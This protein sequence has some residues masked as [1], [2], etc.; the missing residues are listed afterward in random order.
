M[1]RI[2]FF[3]LTVFTV[4]GEDFDFQ[5]W[6]NKY[7]NVSLGQWT[8]ANPPPWRNYLSADNEDCAKKWIITLG[9]LGLRT[10]MHD[11]TWEGRSG[12]KKI[13]PK[14]MC[15]KSSLLYN[16]L[17]ITEVQKGSPAE[18][19]IQKGDLILKIEDQRLVTASALKLNK[20]LAALTV[21][22]LEMHAGMLIDR[23]EGKGKIKM[24]VLRLPENM[25]SKSFST[26]TREW[27]TLKELKLTPDPQKISMELE[28]NQTVRIDYGI[29][30][31]R[32]LEKADYINDN[33]VLSNGTESIRIKKAHGPINL[34]SGKWTLSG[35][36][37]S[38]KRTHVKIE[39]RPLPEFPT[40]LK[41]YLKAV[42]FEIPKVGS[43]GNVYKPNSSKVRTLSKMM[44][45]ALS[46]HQGPDGGWV[47]TKSYAS[48]SFY[49]SICGLAL[50]ATE[51]PIYNQ[52]IKKA[53]Q[54]VAA[55][56]GSQENWTFSRGTQ[57]IFLCEYYL[58]T[59]DAS[60][61]SRAKHLADLCLTHMLTDYTASHKREAAY[62][63]GGFIGSG[64]A[65]VCGLALAN[66]CGLLDQ[67]GKFTVSKALERAQQLAPGGKI[68]YGRYG[69]RNHDI[70][71]DHGGG[72]STGPYFSAALIHG[73][74]KGFIDVTKKR[75]TTGPYG[76]S[77]NGHATQIIHF[78]WSSLAI[79]N[80]G[81]QH[82][83][84]NMSAYIWKLTTERGF[85]G[86]A[87][88]NNAAV[89][90][91]GGDGVIG[92]PFWG[93]ASYLILLNAHKR[94]LAISGK[95]ELLSSQQ[96]ST[97]MVFHGD[98][99]LKN[100]VMRNWAVVNYLIGSK[101]PQVFLETKA[102]ISQ[103]PDDET[104]GPKLIKYLDAQMPAVLQSIH[105]LDWQHPE[106]AKDDLMRM[107]MGL[108]L[109][110][111][112]TMNPL[113][114]GA[115]KK[116]PKEEKNR[117]TKEYNKLVREIENGTLNQ[118]V[119]SQLKFLPVS[120]VGMFGRLCGLE[121]AKYKNLQ[122]KGSITIHK[123]EAAG[124]KSDW[125]KKFNTE[126]PIPSSKYHSIKAKEKQTQKIDLKANPKKPANLNAT[127]QY[128]LCGI[129]ISRKTTLKVFPAKELKSFSPNLSNLWI[130]G[131]LTHDFDG[132]RT[133][134]MRLDNGDIIAAEFGGYLGHR[135]V[136][137][138][139]L[140]GTECE[141]LVSP[142]RQW[143][144]AVNDIKVRKNKRTLEAGVTFDSKHFK[145]KPS[146]LSDQNETSSLIINNSKNER[147]LNFDFPSETLVDTL[148]ISASG[149]KKNDF[150][151][152]V[153]A[154]INNSWTEV[155]GSSLTRGICSFKAV[156][157]KKFRIKIFGASSK[158]T[159]LNELYLNRPLTETEKSQFQLK[160][161][162]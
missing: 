85:Q 70:R 89:E 102:K 99:A 9:P 145:G 95:T 49:T 154:L 142:D 143:S 41:K 87:V 69:A 121:S 91:H 78:L 15:D 76:T 97:P 56:A 86:H 124:I 136:N 25:K 59:K 126:Y 116:M 57:L 16:N 82:H 137:G 127:I 117:I 122:V 31:I 7:G 134:R 112:C 155:F 123:S 12:F 61:L 33:V 114:K 28:G 79:H 74:P 27:K 62:G 60:I 44:A 90:Y 4:Y 43:F 109:E 34:S 162:W 71:N 50:L 140:A 5:K 54:Y 92:A 152:K 156:S 149:T 159:K 42:E 19:Y 146:V 108:K 75:Y 130:K 32:S 88:F 6:Q 128:N 110:L 26:K 129:P 150:V 158:S 133:L 40:S 21:R 64:S 37:S 100:H 139:L 13:Y 14:A 30:K 23:A 10:L 17:E 113:N 83:I 48:R 36:L 151:F 148:V 120:L 118:A 55:V 67:Q 53:A 132:Q 105:K 107:L 144:L 72:F 135:D 11:I 29:S 119:D 161:T 38:S 47:Q 131:T 138:I 81:D 66:K 153:E 46:Q 45:H 3:F 157:S 84:N 94:N 58:R 65:L 160:G 98:K 77:E 1:S 51:D 106:I 141:I 2:L 111:K 39:T 52:Q 20:P 115:L 73:G 68:P 147:T 96:Q 103:F 101:A 80:C 93:T 125:V 22:G 63:G 24:T 104:L 8:A 35:I 18:G